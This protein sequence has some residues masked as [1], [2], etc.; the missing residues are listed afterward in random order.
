MP[1]D[2][3]KD[4]TTTNDPVVDPKE[5]D[6]TQEDPKEDLTREE[7]EVEDAL[8]AVN[9][10]IKGELKPNRPL[11]EEQPAEE[12]GKPVENEEEKQENKDGEQGKKEDEVVPD[13]TPETDE[14]GVYT[15]PTATDPGE[16]KPKDYSFSIQ[17]TDGKTHKIS[18]PED[19]ESFATQ[20]DEHPEL[21]TAS[22]F[23]TLG[24]KTATMEQNLA[25]D[26]ESYDQAKVKFEEE[27]TQ[28]TNREQYLTQWQGEINYLRQKGELPAIT[29]ELNNADWTD[30]KVAASPGVKEALAI[31]KWMEE[32]NNNRMA[33]GLPPDLSVV[34]AFNTMQLEAIRN[35]EKDTLSR[36]KEATRKRGAMVGGKAPYTPSNT[37]KGTL[38]GPA[39]GLDDLATE[40]YYATE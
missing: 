14:T 17:T 35:E 15:P 6:K 27:Q 2:E 30:P 31:F 34:S 24:R 12:P 10:D 5:P 33:V 8:L 1:P 32:E 7:Q 25:R 37:P 26:Q 22:Q 38:V 19:A 18:S 11:E 20:L 9:G 21:I 23:L 16:F 36:E 40:A 29:N 28:A 13:I 39:R 4:D 3:N